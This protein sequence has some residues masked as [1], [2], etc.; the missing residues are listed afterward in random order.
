MLVNNLSFLSF[1]SNTD[2]VMNHIAQRFLQDP[3]RLVREWNLAMLKLQPGLLLD[4]KYLV[5]YK[6]HLDQKGR[7]TVV[8]GG[9]FFFA[10]IYLYDM[11]SSL[12]ESGLC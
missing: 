2:T 8:S 4:E 5:L 6:P 9:S 1:E 3:V 12:P 11:N 10:S 7:V